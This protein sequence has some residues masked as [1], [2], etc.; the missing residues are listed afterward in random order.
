MKRLTRRLQPMSS[1]EA[2]KDPGHVRFF[3]LPGGETFDGL[4]LPVL[5]GSRERL[6]VLPA[7]QGKDPGSALAGA[8]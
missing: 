7:R 4:E 2:P 8:A 1:G 6:L 5:P 3:I